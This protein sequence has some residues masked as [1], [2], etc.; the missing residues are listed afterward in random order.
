MSTVSESIPT[1]DQTQAGDTDQVG[2][3]RATAPSMAFYL[4][5]PIFEEFDPEAMARR[6]QSQDRVYCLLTEKEYNH[7]VGSEDIILYILDRRP[8]LMANMRVLLGQESWAEQEL[9]LV[10]NRPFEEAAPEGRQTP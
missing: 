2:Y 10:S 4:R 3:F 6:F 7:F 1:P 8:R 5:R 9:L